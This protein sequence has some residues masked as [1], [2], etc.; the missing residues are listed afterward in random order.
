MT[1]G[2]KICKNLDYGDIIVMFSEA[3]A[4]KINFV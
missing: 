3:K 2:N 4:R 1:N